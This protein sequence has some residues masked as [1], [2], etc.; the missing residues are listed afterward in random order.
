MASIF[1]VNEVLSALTSVLQD[2]KKQRN[3]FCP[4]ISMSPVSK[5]HEPQDTPQHLI[6][7]VEFLGQN[8]KPQTASASDHILQEETWSQILT[9]YQDL[10][11]H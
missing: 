3:A 1:K 6:A 9:T 11:Q 5:H 7:K 10:R 4:Q 8:Q 2:L